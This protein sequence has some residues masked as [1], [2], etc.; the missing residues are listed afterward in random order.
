[1]P[2]SSNS[3]AQYNARVA[4]TIKERLGVPVDKLLPESLTPPTFS[5]HLYGA[6]NKLTKI[7]SDPEVVKRLL[8]QEI[9]RRVNAH[10]AGSR[11]DIEGVDRRGGARSN[12]LCACDV[13]A[14]ITSMSSSR[15]TRHHSLA[16]S[17]STSSSSHAL[18]TIHAKP[19]N[20]ASSEAATPV[21]AAPNVPSS[22]GPSKPQKY[23]ES[24]SRHIPIAQSP[25]TPTATRRHIGQYGIGESPCPATRTR[26]SEA[27]KP[28]LDMQTTFGDREPDQHSLINSHD[29]NTVPETPY[30]SAAAINQIQPVV[31]TPL[32][33]IGGTG[34]SPDLGTSLPRMPSLFKAFR[35]ITALRI[36]AVSTM[37]DDGQD[38]PV[39]AN[40]N[41][42]NTSGTESFRE[43]S[44]YTINA[45]NAGSK[46]RKSL[47]ADNNMTILVDLQDRY[48]TEIQG[49][50]REITHLTTDISFHQQR[51]TRA[52]SRV[53]DMSKKA[54]EREV[55]ASAVQ[56]KIES[57]RKTLENVKRI[58]DEEYAK[59]PDAT[60]VQFMGKSKSA[61]EQ[62]VQS[63]ETELVEMR[64]SW[65]ADDEELITARE[66]LSIA[67]ARVKVDT[68]K[69][70]RLEK[71]SHKRRKTEEMAAQLIKLENELQNDVD[72]RNDWNDDEDEN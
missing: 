31:A 5:K 40:S 72:D 19:E 36:P 53:T 66:A 47:A 35:G 22:S 65:K 32:Q 57:G 67:K 10:S 33:P 50:W 55:Q 71:R 29:P 18:S 14:V 15:S 17:V 16:S 56:A 13:Q 64:D 62:A 12:H 37:A 38:T 49:L 45:T 59:D 51:V 43:D 54:A 2:S 63:A 23:E 9:H 46:K 48:S 25:S 27:L 39:H 7:E 34:A 11:G 8:S 3:T 6:L 21:N 4:A 30:P 58:Y 26:A 70:S 68:K 61:A 41:V 69:K 24:S 28:E 42:S 1:M 20:S 60:V 52:Q 44:K